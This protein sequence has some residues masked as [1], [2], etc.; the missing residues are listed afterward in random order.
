M[1]FANKYG[2]VSNR[3][4]SGIFANSGGRCAVKSENPGKWVKSQ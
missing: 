2:P 1:S 4:F 3:R